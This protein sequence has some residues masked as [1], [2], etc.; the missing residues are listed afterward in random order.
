M[1]YIVLTLTLLVYSCASMDY[2]PE[3]I[4]LTQDS[5]F[6][7][8]IDSIDFKYAKIDSFFEVKHKKQ[9]FNG[10]VLAAEKGKLIYK[11][12]FGFTNFRSKN[13]VTTETPFQLASV[14]KPFTA[15]AVLILVDEGK[16]SLDDDIRKFFPNFPYEDVTV[17]LLLIHR[18]GLSNYMY[19]TDKHWKD[20]KKPVTNDEVIRLYEKY[21]PMH[22]YKPNVRYN[23]S[24]TGYILLASIVEKVSGMRFGEF[25][26]QNIFEPTGM[27]NSFL[28][29]KNLNNL[30]EKAATG[31]YRWNRR[32]EDT[33]LNGVIGDKG[34][35]SSAEDLL[36][37]DRALNGGALLSDSLQ[38][39]AYSPAH[40]ELLINDNYGFGWRINDEDPDNKIVYHSGWWKGFRSYFIRELGEKKTIIV[41]SNVSRNTPISIR[42]LLDLF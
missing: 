11:N 24:N 30:R 8:S 13:R 19:F 40:P 31:Y 33:Y 18:G 21:H 29:N 32:A 34:I 36:K 20:K 26:K 1:R 14:S 37:F 10:A 28:Y 4:P 6:A 15:T 35:Y 3:E 27:T 22:Y 2:S 42:E 23:Y 41:L 39:L 9:G 25:L 17:R 16:I 7:V 5:L 12:G 38:T